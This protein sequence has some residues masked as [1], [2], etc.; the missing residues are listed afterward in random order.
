MT[1]LRCV[2][3]DDD[4]QQ[5]RLTI[6]GANGLVAQVELSPGYATVIAARLVDA[7]GHFCRRTEAPGRS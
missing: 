6:Y 5:I 3:T 2:V 7:V 4:G 1:A